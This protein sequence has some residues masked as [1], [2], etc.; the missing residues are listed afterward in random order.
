MNSGSNLQTS[1]E[2]TI[3]E[4]KANVLEAKDKQEVD[5]DNDYEEE[6]DKSIVTKKKFFKYIYGLR[7]Y[8]STLNDTTDRD[9]N[10]LYSLEKKILTLGNS[11]Q[12]KMDIF[13]LNL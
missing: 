2:A 7:N 8:I 1:P 5:A 3:T 11:H 9:Y 6:P 4:I 13:F 12:T 10:M